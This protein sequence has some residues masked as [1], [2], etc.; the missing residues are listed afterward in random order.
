MFAKPGG[1]FFWLCG[2][3]YVLEN[4]LTSPGMLKRSVVVQ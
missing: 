4:V 3:P 2:I 1:M